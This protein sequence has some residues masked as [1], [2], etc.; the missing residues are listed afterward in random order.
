[1]LGFFSGR[2]YTTPTIFNPVLDSP[3]RIPASRFSVPQSNHPCVQW[4]FIGCRHSLA[5]LINHYE[6]EV[7]VWD[8]II[9]QQHH[10]PLPLGLRNNEG[11]GG[12]KWYWHAAVLCTGAKEMPVRGDCFS[13]PFKMVLL[14]KRFMNASACLY[15]S[16]CGVWGDIVSMPITNTICH[17]KPN[18]LVGNALY[19][20][21]TNGDVLAFD[22][23]R[24][25]FVVIK[26]PKT[27]RSINYYSGYVQVL[28]TADKGLGL[29]YFSQQTIQ[30]WERRY[31]REDV[32]RWVLLPKT[33]PI[34]GM[35]PWET[36]GDDK[37]VHFM[38]YDENRNVI[39]LATRI[40]TFMI[41]LD[42]M[43]IRLIIGRNEMCYDKFHPYT[44][45]YA[46]G[47]IY[48][49]LHYIALA[50]K[51]QVD[52]VCSCSC[53]VVTSRTHTDKKFCFVQLI[54]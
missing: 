15:D 8:P 40:G 20:M 44:N 50:S 1:L 12:N 47:N 9:N 26:K 27:P 39:V 43:Q 36:H 4:R 45:F 38:G 35:L 34:A 2:N 11:E 24:Q 51:I 53:W 5:I 7:V 10:V 6:K 30:L 52:S 37:S 49:N 29:A 54:L 41:Q 33:I 13:S 32:A 31:N 16:A 21:F 23:Q 28:R 14:G 19:C 17:I 18:V 42:M 46:E 25:R 48:C 3:D 22:F